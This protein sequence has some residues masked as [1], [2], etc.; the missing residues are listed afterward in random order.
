M[1]HLLSLSASVTLGMKGL[2]IPAIT[3]RPLYHKGC[4]I[5]SGR[6]H[7]SASWD[8]QADVHIKT[9]GQHSHMQEESVSSWTGVRGG[10][11]EQW[12]LS[13]YIKSI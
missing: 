10:G 8:R 12:G 3:W 13:G 11:G 2:T 1:I 7:Q 4:T 9:A 5:N 6:L